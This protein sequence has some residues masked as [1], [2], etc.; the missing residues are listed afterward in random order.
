MSKPFLILQLRPE[1]ETS[2]N[3]LAAVM[4]FGGLAENEIHRVRLERQ[5]IAGLKLDDFTAVYVGGG[6]Y[7]V[8]DPESKK[9]GEQLRFEKE[10]TQ[11][12]EQI[13][14]ED[15]PFLGGCYGLGCLAKVLGAT[16][17]TSRYAEGVEGLT[18]HLT[19]AASDDP[20]TQGLPADFRAFAGHKESVQ[21]V[22]P[23]ATLLGS[24]DVCPVH[25][26]RVKQNIYA[27]QFHPELDKEG[28]ALRISFYK[29]KGYFPPE[30]ADKLIEAANQ[31]N[32][33]VPEKILHRFVERYRNG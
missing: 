7:N 31:E 22:P 24:S 25:M 32:I 28:I 23:G 27:T 3:E 29:H 9:P 17:D 33:F 4:K 5:S 14:A 18:I 21:E 13:I 20:I 1:D 16:V 19:D 10:L 12:L 2:D 26:I 30:D 15:K 11:L 8:S 6:P